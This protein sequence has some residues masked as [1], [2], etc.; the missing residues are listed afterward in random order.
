MHRLL[1]AW[2]LVIFTMDC[3]VAA[4]LVPITLASAGPGNLAYLPVDLIKRIGADRDEGVDLTVHYFGGGPMAYKDM[5]EHNADFAVGG[6]PALAGLKLRGEPVTSIATVNRAPAFTLLVR[7]DLRGRIRKIADLRGRVIGVTTSSAKTKSTSQ[8]VAEFA[9]LRAGV[10]LDQVNFLA[11]GQSFEDQMAALETGAVDA[12]MG[13]EP[14]A[15]Q[16]RETGMGYVLLDLHDLPTTRAAMGGLF[17]NTQ[18]AARQDMLAQHPDKAERM[19]RVMQRTLR[20]IAAHR[21]EEVVAKLGMA[22]T[23][24][25]HAL[26]RVLANHKAIFSPDGAFTQE[27]ISVAER[28]FQETNAAISGARQFSFQSMIEP[29]WAGIRVH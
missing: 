13:F 11:A 25:R 21:A 28:F 9:L 15:T 1:L 18:L 26:L 14:F 3:S 16:V 27:Q 19:V 8:Q 5:L 23:K 22:D 24:A 12:L 29:R 17:L 7:S 10:R 4:T 6:A 20:W 2:L